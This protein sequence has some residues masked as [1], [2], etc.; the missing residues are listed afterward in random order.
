MAEVKTFDAA[1]GDGGTATLDANALLPATKR[2]SR[3]FHPAVL[4]DAVVLYE[5]NRRVGTVQT[6]ERHFVSGSTKKMYKQK[7]TGNARQGDGKAPHFRGGG[8]CFGPH[9]RE[10]RKS[11]PRRALR[12]ALAVALSRKIADGEVTVV[13]SLAF[14][15]PST[16]AYARMIAAA[17][18]GHAP[19]LVVAGK[20]DPNVLKS[21]RNIPRSRVVPA[22]ELNA[23]DVAACTRLLLVEGAWDAIAARLSGGARE[24][25]SS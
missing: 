23:H 19:L 11:M 13:R 8:I 5:A 21:A 4:R 20:A 6:K 25:E 2:E 15:K 12:K 1:S 24:G 10:Y 3:G 9:P 7:H 17:D 18:G 14:D 22:D 16:K